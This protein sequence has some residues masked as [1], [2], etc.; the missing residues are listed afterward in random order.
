MRH[1]RHRPAKRIVD[2]LLPR[3][4][5]EMIVAADYVGDRHIMIVDHDR[6]HISRGAVGAQKHEIVET[7]ALPDHPALNLIL[8]HGLTGERRLEPDRRL[9]PGWRFAWVAVAP[10]AVIKLGAAFAARR[11]AHLRKL[12][13][14][15]VA[16]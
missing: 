14:A 15:G 10:A 9:D 6:E 7:F 16:T 8:D 12:L 3:G 2:L 11:L 1:H 13:G 4:I 5:G